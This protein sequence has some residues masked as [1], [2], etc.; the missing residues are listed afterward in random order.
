MTDPFTKFAQAL[1]CR[2][3]TAPVVARALRDKWFGCYGVPVQLHSDQGR[4]F[5]SDE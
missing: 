5:E 2:D 4:N 3:Q 1:P